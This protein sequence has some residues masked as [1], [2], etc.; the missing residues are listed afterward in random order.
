MFISLSQTL[1]GDLDSLSSCR[2]DVWLVFCCLTFLQHVPNAEDK[3][4]SEQH[5][6]PGVFLC[7]LNIDV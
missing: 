6:W 1:A 4:D 7:A 2:N 5:S 3:H